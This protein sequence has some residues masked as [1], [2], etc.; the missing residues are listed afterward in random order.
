MRG[1][2]TRDSQIVPLF[3]PAENSQFVLMNPTGGIIRIYEL[4]TTFDAENKDEHLKVPRVM[5]ITDPELASRITKGNTVHTA[6]SS[7]IGENLFLFDQTR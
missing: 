5:K 6:V 7:Q 1:A 2:L 4:Q 3:A